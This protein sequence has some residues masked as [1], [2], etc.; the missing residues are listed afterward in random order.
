MSE[1]GA[2][3]MLSGQTLADISKQMVIFENDSESPSGEKKSQ[4]AAEN[5]KKLEKGGIFIPYDYKKR[6]L[7]DNELRKNNNESPIDTLSLDE[8]LVLTALDQKVYFKGEELSVDD[9]QHRLEQAAEQKV[10]ALS[11]S[12]IAEAGME[13][14]M[15]DGLT[16]LRKQLTEITSLPKAET[17]PSLNAM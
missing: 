7:S 9:V 2:G 14:R 8:L 1:V 11:Q 17:N 10:T 16:R 6:I 15:I 3:E 12:P 5:A 13:R 4:E